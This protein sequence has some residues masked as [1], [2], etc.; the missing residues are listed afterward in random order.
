M[1]SQGSSIWVVSVLGGAPRKLRDNATADAISPDGSF[2]SFG[3]N[4]G[5]IG[6]RE[7][8]LM[9]PSGEVSLEREG[10]IPRGRLF[11]SN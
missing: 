9:D 4:K 8:W 6:D 3:T 2:I 1:N 10:A 7:S 11:G 5:R